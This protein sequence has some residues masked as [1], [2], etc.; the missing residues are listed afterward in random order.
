MDTLVKERLKRNE[1]VRGWVAGYLN[2][3]CIDGKVINSVV[4]VCY[5]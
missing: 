4:I 5:G 3:G 1:G 2:Q